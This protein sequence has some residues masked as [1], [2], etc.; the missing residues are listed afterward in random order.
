MARGTTHARILGW[1]ASLSDLL[2]RL[3]SFILLLLLL[4][5]TCLHKGTPI[6]YLTTPKIR[7]ELI[8]P[9][10]CGSSSQLHIGAFFSVFKTRRT[11]Y[12]GFVLARR[13]LIA[14]LLSA[15]P[16]SSSW[17]AGA[18]ALLLSLS[19]LATLSLR[20]WK[21]RIQNT[22]E[23]L[24]F[25]TQMVNVVV[26]EAYYQAHVQIVFY[27]SIT[28]SSLL[29]AFLILGYPAYYAF[30]TETHYQKRWKELH[31]Q[32]E[33]EKAQKRTL[34]LNTDESDESDADETA[35]TK[36]SW[37]QLRDDY[38]PSNRSNSS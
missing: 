11:W 37:R 2:S 1:F 17:H 33:A 16:S 15:I 34:H 25:T 9:V 3:V 31:P 26:S 22:A 18:L 32:E 7:V 35:S 36:S 27:T 28:L 38:V 12:S 13:V 20:P 4:Y 24:I 21:L 14:I 5:N 8:V 30:T 19:L 10:S 6:I 23:A 29:L